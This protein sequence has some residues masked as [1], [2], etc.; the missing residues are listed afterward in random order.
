VATRVLIDGTNVSEKLDASMFKRE[1]AGFS[2]T[3]VPTY[4]TTRRHI[5]DKNDRSIR[6][7]ENFKSHVPCQYCIYPAEQILGRQEPLYPHLILE[8]VP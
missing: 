7:R 2:G 5:P 6:N 3:L 1:A 8:D 4:E